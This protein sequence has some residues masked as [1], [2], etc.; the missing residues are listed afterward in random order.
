MDFTDL[1]IP[2]GGSSLTAFDPSKP[3]DLIERG[4]NELD[5]APDADYCF[6]KGQEARENR[7]YNRAIG[8][9]EKALKADPEHEDSLFWMGYCYLPFNNR[10]GTE[11][12][13]LGL[14]QEA[15]SKRAVD[16]YLRLIE[17]KKRSGK[18]SGGDSASFNNL[19][20]AY[21][22]LGNIEKEEE[23][24]KKAVK[25][26]PDDKVAWCNLGNVNKR[27]ALYDEAVKC[28]SRSLEIDPEYAVAHYNMALVYETKKENKMALKYFRSY[29]EYVDRTDPWEKELIDYTLDAIDRFK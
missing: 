22:K 29:L 8:W 6:E 5:E 3:N 14:D 9:Y 11:N 16:C 28:L 24:Y 13:I 4:L 23:S 20:V 15:C 27:N 7:E 26:N 2:K 17:L 21:G 18:L 12:E 25:L 1:F 19:G 10:I